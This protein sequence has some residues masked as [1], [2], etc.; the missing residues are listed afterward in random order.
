MTLQR[1]RRAML[2]MP[3]DDRRK[4]EKGASAGADS[5]IMDLEDAVTLANKP[6]A[7]AAVAAALREV[8][9]GTVER[10][11]RLNPVSSGALCM[12]DLEGTVD[13]RPDAYVLPKVESAADISHIDSWMTAA[14]QQRGW[15]PGEIRLIAIIETAMGIVRLA[16]IAAASRRLDALAFGA[17]D[18]A[19]DMGAV[20]TQN[21]HES[22]Y[23]RSAVVLHAK[24]FGLQALD[25]PFINFKADETLLVADARCAMEMGYTGKFA[26][27]PRQVNPIQQVFTP[28]AEQIDRARR[29]VTEFDAREAAGEGVFAFEGK[30]IDMPMIRAAR[31]VLERA[32]AAGIRV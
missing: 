5:I 23:A 2:F 13:G 22:Q 31:W 29:L 19:G 3:G 6:A 17:E 14:E 26:I 21:G 28:T 27:H 30:M 10:T 18:L 4:I 15:P 11:V 25:T 7:R 9:F 32:R 16:E 24:A 8:D 1:V 20:R 12:L